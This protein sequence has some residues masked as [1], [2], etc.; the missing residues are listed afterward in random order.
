[1]LISKHKPQ[2][3]DNSLNSSVIIR[4]VR[5]T[6]SNEKYEILVYILQTEGN[7]LHDYIHISIR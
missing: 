7:M 2:R 6:F 1:M 3:E 5:S 4:G